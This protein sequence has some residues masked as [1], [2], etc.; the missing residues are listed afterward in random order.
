[1]SGLVMLATTKNASYDRDE[2]QQSGTY[3]SRAD[4][5]DPEVTMGEGRGSFHASLDQQIS[6]VLRKIE[7][8]VLLTF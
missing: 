8:E 2:D 1:M 5:E 7:A 3:N 6:N 4:K